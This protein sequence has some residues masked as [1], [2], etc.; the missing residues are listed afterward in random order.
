MKTQ[1]IQPELNRPTSSNNSS[2]VVAGTAGR[3][4]TAPSG[5]GMRGLIR[6]HPLPAFFVIAFTL[7]WVTV[8]L[9][10]FMAAG[11]LV[12]ALVVTGIVDGRAGLRELRSRMLRWRVGVQWYAAAILIPLG[13]ALA[14]GGLNV[15]FGASDSAFAKL[16]VS[17]LVMMFAMRLVVPVAGPIGEE[18]GWRGFALPRL[19]AERSPLASTLI[20]G[21]VVALWHLPL[22]FL[23]QEHFS[24][25]FLVATV[26]V[27]FFYTWIF[28]HT[29]GSVFMT[30]VAHAAEG[31][32]AAAFV[33][34][35][36]F[37]GAGE[38]R[39][40]VLYTAGWCVVAIVLVVFDRKMWRT[41][42][43]V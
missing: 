22:I 31:L 41:P 14:T 36:G 21:I 30:I 37:T 4:G 42:A 7:T 17:A 11:P 1:V 3:A 8:P 23:T 24:P 29:R 38:T 28:N 26:A 27:T 34:K 16:E 25:I 6:R 12:A 39:F 43:R 32:I 20:L 19:Q 33:G 35:D 10:M 2:P 13:V 40:A 5:S 15:A 9:G 18:P